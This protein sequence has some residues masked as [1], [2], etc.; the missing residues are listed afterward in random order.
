MIQ[1]IINTLIKTNAGPTRLLK[2]LSKR[3]HFYC[4]MCDLAWTFSVRRG[5]ASAAWQRAWGRLYRGG[6]RALWPMGKPGL[7]PKVLQ[8]QPTNETSTYST[9][10]KYLQY[11]LH[12]TVRPSVL[13]QMR[14]CG[15]ACRSSVAQSTGL[16]QQ[17]VDM[18]ARKHARQEFTTLCHYRYMSV[19]FWHWGR[20]AGHS[21]QVGPLCCTGDWRVVLPIIFVLEM[22]VW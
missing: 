17:L 12:F 3:Q 10:N 22:A 16:I 6:T 4:V 15:A 21:L 19:L 1:R 18:Q 8:L 13:Q 2:S 20:A 11:L 7:G 14:A 9:W 5:R